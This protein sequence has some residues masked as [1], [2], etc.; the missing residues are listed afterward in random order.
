MMEYN[1][2]FNDC[3]IEA[4]VLE[5]FE[6][7][8]NPDIKLSKSDL[9]KIE[10]NLSPNEIKNVQLDLGVFG[11]DINIKNAIPLY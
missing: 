9:S 11:S 5:F 1:S 7:N 8:I 10:N 3:K 4:V 6:V 2:I